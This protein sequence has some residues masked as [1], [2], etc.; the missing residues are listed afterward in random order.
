MIDA[1]EFDLA[2]AVRSA[3][4]ARGDAALE[5]ADDLLCHV[6]SPTSVM[7]CEAEAERRA[8]GAALDDYLA[9]L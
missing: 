7:Q 8:G 6:E 1:G 3:G 4:L 9:K 2:A 5:L